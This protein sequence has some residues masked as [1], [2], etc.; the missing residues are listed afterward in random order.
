MRLLE[1]GGMEVSVDETVRILARSGLVLIRQGS[2]GEVQSLLSRW[3]LPVDHPHQTVSGL[4]VIR[5]REC[6]DGIHNSLGFTNSALSPH[7]DRSLQQEPPSLLATVM[8]SAAKAGGEALLVDGADVLADLRHRFDD[9]TVASMRLRPPHGDTAPRVVDLSG[10]FARLRFRDDHLARPHSVTGSHDVVSEMRRLTLRLSE[11]F[12]LSPGDGY[13]LHNHR[14]LH[15]RSA[16]TG[17]N[18]S[19][20]RLLARV[21]IRHPYAWLNR[22]FRLA[23]P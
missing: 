4:T 2:V 21:D 9:A 12:P 7:T 11:T 18:R 23:N 14:I 20:V 1:A 19:V 10:G 22:G 5:P 8:V 17:G 13:I 6:H 3:T 15:G 16:F